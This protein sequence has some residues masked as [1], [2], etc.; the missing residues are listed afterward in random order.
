MVQ[1]CK[2]LLYYI[3]HFEDI[4]FSMLLTICKSF[5]VV[6]LFDLQADDIAGFHA[7]TH[8]PVVVGAQMRY[9]VTGDLLYK[10]T[11]FAFKI[12]G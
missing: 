8:I 6:I 1:A 9:E 10:V 3:S 2:E 11:Y 5:R 4:S 12:G 7:N